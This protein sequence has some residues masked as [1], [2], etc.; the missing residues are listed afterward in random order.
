[1]RKNGGLAVARRRTWCATCSAER[2]AT[3][4]NGAS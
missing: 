2:S 3:R 4:N 1:V